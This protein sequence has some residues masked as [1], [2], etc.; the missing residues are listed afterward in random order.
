MPLKASR[1][2]QVPPFLVMDVMRDAAQLEAAGRNI[3]HL[4]VGQPS[5]G[6][7]KKA[8]KYLQEIL[9]QERLGYTLTSGLTRLRERIAQH[10]LDMYQVEVE[11][12][13]IFVTTGSSAGFLLAFLAAFDSGDRV[14]VPCPGYPAYRHILNTVG[15]ETLLLSVDHKS[16]FQPTIKLLEAL[17]EIP[18]GIIVASP[19]NPTGTTIPA[20]ALT[21]ITHYCDANG[22]RLISDEIYHGITYGPEPLT[23]ASL[24]S[25]SLVINSFSKYYSMTGWRLGWMV[26]PED[27]QRSV[28]CLSQNL[29]ISPPALS[30][31]GAMHVF[32]CLDELDDNV[33]RYKKNRRILLHGL[34]LAGFKN[35]APVDGAFYVYADVRHLT[36][37]SQSFCNKML[38]EAGVAA[39]PGIDFDPINGKY[40]V[41][42]SFAGTN[43]DMEEACLRLQEWLK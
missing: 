15:V 41:R 2:G 37:D 40:Y 32:E 42:F 25:S 43:S 12:K 6:I 27:L 14:A 9:E 36:D 13:R 11:A 29:F 5:T 22:I 17:P 1:R 20:E 28:E 35:L 21:E 34:P 18:H 24:S 7:P 8:S 19:S 31:F 16:R 38:L 39:T 3:I 33:S 26:V 4:E 23:V 10:Y 30:Q